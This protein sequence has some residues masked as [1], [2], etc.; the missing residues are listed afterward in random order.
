MATRTA[1][2]NNLLAQLQGLQADN[3]NLSRQLQEALDKL[4]KTD[5]VVLPAEVNNALTEFAAQNPDLVDFD[6]SRGV[7]KFKSDVTFN[8]GSA[9]VKQHRARRNRPLCANPQLQG[10]VRL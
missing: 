10:R 4:G 8:T 3:S 6:A 2:A 7:V 5:V 1:L 9:E